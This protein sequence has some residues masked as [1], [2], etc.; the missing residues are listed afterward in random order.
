MNVTNKDIYSLLG[1]AVALVNFTSFPPQGHVAVA[2]ELTLHEHAGHELLTAYWDEM[3]RLKIKELDEGQHLKT[4]GYKTE[5]KS[6]YHLRLPL[7]DL[8]DE[9]AE[10]ILQCGLRD[11][12]Y[13]ANG[14]GCT[15]IVYPV[16]GIMNNGWSQEQA[17]KSLR[18][19]TKDI[20]IK[21]TAV[22]F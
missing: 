10:W 5:A 17:L 8:F 20:N 21:V 12:A 2:S 15:E 13:G 3:K 9:T 11:V 1:P 16:T 22:T 6:I 7:D 18:E 14:E 19:A 4:E